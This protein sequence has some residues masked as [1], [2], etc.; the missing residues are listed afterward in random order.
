MAALPGGIPV[1][2]GEKQGVSEFLFSAMETPDGHVRRG[3]MITSDP[4][5]VFGAH[6]A[7]NYLRQVVKL[8][9][10]AKEPIDIQ[11]VSIGGRSFSRANAGVGQQV[12]SFG[13][14]LSTVCGDYFLTFYFSGPSQES[15][16]TLVRTLEQLSLS[17]PVGE[18]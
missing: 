6:D 7:S 5:G 8:S 11:S 1:G 18:R 3:V 16:E 10:G 12:R 15:T 9:M 4:I 17:C 2:T 14:Q 13:A